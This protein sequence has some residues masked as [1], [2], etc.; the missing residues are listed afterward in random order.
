VD[1]KNIDQIDVVPGE[2]A[3][4][5]E[6]TAFFMCIDTD[7]LHTFQ[8][9][10]VEGRNLL[11]EMGTDTASVL[12]NETAART[13]G[14]EHP[15]GKE[16]HVQGYNYSPRIVGVVHDFSF[17]SLHQKIA[18]LVLG[19]W[20][21]PVTSI[22]Y[23]TVRVRSADLAQTLNALKK[24]HERFDQTTPFEFNFLDDRLKDFY[25][26]DMRMGKIF[27]LS[28][29]M[30]IM[31]ACMGVLGLVTFSAQQRTR[32]IGVRKV[33]G[34]SE[35]QIVYLLSKEYSHLVILATLLASPIAYLAVERWLSS[36][37]YR[38]DIGWATFLLA[39][40]CALLLS[41]LTVGYQ[42]IRAA[43]QNPAVALRYE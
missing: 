13:F 17:E 23:F 35:G 37:A 12:V 31:I 36:F 15:I 3:T 27:A 34:A 39:G 32:E 9:R 24:I 43:A 33:L 14:W 28:A 6:H 29:G 11:A 10:L 26:A 19:H 4:P 7:F 38:V 2:P 40:I 22:D 41:L 16:I 5:Q 30:A 42:A 20:N 1:W 18:P 21:N 8:M 25:Q